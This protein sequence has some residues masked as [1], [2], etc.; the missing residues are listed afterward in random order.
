MDLIIDQDHESGYNGFFPFFK[1]QIPYP[2]SIFLGKAQ[3][4]SLYSRLSFFQLYG[5]AWQWTCC[6]KNRTQLNI[7]LQ[8]YSDLQIALHRSQSFLNLITCKLYTTTKSN[9][10]IFITLIGHLSRNNYR[11]KWRMQKKPAILGGL[12]CS[13]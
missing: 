3:K 8:I 6:M 13:S 12:A 5:K 1:K 2:L 10:Y 9:S 11:P 4:Q 7:N